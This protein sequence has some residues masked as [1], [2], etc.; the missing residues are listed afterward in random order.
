[1]VGC[2]YW[3]YMPIYGCKRWMWWL[4]WGIDIEYIHPYM[5]ILVIE[6][7][8]LMLWVCEY[9]VDCLKDCKMCYQVEDE[10]RHGR[11]YAR[12]RFCQFYHWRTRSYKQACGSPC[13]KRFLNTAKDTGVSRARVGHC[14]F[15]QNKKN[16]YMGV[17]SARVQ[18]AYLY[19][20]MDTGVSKPLLASVLHFLV[21]LHSLSEFMPWPPKITIKMTQMNQNKQHKQLKY[22]NNHKN[23]QIQIKSVLKLGCLPTSAC[24][25]SLAQPNP[26]FMLKADGG[27]MTPQL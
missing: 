11:V 23:C 19:M 27:E 10:S 6:R 8:L 26:N 2:R 24:L 22:N 4:W 9:V 16:E 13:L 25:G 20:P 14:Q 7:L 21:L 17:F 18:H 15:F 3:V 1:M 12:V 5:F